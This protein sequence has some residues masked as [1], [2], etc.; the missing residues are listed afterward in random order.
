VWLIYPVELHWKQLVSLCHCLSVADSFLV[1]G[2][3]QCLLSPL[4]AGLHLETA[5]L[6]PVEILCM[7]PQSLW[8]HMCI[9]PV[10][11]GSTVSLESSITSGSYDLFAPSSIQIKDP[12]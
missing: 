12:I 1:R 8:V 3:T 11:S 2:G 10:L 5:E 6:E 4:C 7:L 9:I